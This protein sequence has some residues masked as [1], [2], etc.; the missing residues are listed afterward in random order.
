MKQKTSFKEYLESKELLKLALDDAPKVKEIYEVEKYCN[1]P[2]LEADG[3]TSQVKL[4]PKD[5][6]EILW[7]S[8]PT[9]K[10][11]KSFCLVVEGEVKSFAWSNAKV[12]SWVSKMTRQI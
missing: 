10:N 12:R 1:L 5:W 6:I 4:K 8:T 2:F 3:S 9:E 11:P 7:E